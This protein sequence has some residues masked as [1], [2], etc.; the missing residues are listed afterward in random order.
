MFE[1]ER[2]ED[3]PLHTA[4]CNGDGPEVRRLLE[5]GESVNENN[6]HG[7][8]PLHMATEANSVEAVKAML[9]YHADVNC[10][11]GSRGTTAAHVAAGS[12]YVG[13]LEVL[14]QAGADIDARNSW[15]DSVLKVAKKAKKACKPN[16][17]AVLA[18][19]TE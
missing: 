19:L 8:F 14:L 4:A 9:E 10:S 1:R 17:E 5:A 12:G 2:F 11:H 7:S 18:L 13:V 3:H 15:G 6:F 16:A